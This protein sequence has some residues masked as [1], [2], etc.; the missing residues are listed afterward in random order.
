MDL[1][2]IQLGD[3]KVDEEGNM[4]GGLY[5]PPEGLASEMIITSDML[6]ENNFESLEHITVKI[7]VNHTRRG[8]VEVE[9]ISPQGVR[10]M[11]AG[12]RP[13]DLSKSGFLGW[14]F[15]TLKHW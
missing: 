6:L 3:G 8:D 13:R 5:I 7:W 15:M 11:L 10:S 9:L 2:V 12:P 4:L 14:T 1:P